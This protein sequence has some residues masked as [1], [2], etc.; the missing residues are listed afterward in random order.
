[1]KAIDTFAPSPSDLG[2]VADMELGGLQ[3][4]WER[5]VIAHAQGKSDEAQRLHSDLVRSQDDF[6]RRWG[7]RPIGA[8][9]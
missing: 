5:L 8:L 2:D 3:I 7:H 1:M 9:I 4:A 6:H